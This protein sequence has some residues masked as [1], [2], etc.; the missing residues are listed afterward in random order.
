VDGVRAT[1]VS[2][3]VAPARVELRAIISRASN[4]VK[5]LGARSLVR[6]L[7]VEQGVA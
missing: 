6:G 4:V 7:T 2:F 3:D 1:A 5:G